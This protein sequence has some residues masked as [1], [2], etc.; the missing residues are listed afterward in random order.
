MPADQTITSP[1]RATFKRSGNAIALFRMSVFSWSG[2]PPRAR[3]V[4]DWVT[5]PAQAKEDHTVPLPAG[6]YIVW[7]RS[8]ASTDPHGAQGDV[9][10]DFLCNGSPVL[11]AS[12]DVAQTPDAVSYEDQ[13]NLYAHE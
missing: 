6:Q 11:H 10:L 13:F 4:D 12:G 3:L 7:F 5:D 9:T 8:S 2:T 1:L